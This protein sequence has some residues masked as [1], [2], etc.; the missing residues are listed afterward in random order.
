[1]SSPV[2]KLCARLEAVAGTLHEPEDVR[3]TDARRRLTVK[4]EELPKLDAQLSTL[5]R[6]YF[7][8]LTRIVRTL[9]DSRFD[10]LSSRE[11]MQ[12]LRDHARGTLTVL[13]STQKIVGVIK[14]RYRALN[15]PAV[16]GGAEGQLG[17]LL[18]TLKGN[19][20]VL[21]ATCRAVVAELESL[22]HLYAASKEFP[23]VYSSEVR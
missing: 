20:G 6:T 3:L 7:D 10:R 8:D 2:E 15:A 1:M 12:R 23:E 18:N 16:Q 21:P 5:N 14:D 4:L 17:D 13:E 9:S 22:D 11:H 19:L